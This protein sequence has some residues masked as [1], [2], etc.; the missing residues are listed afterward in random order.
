MKTPIYKFSKDKIKYIPL[1]DLHVGSQSFDEEALLATVEYIRKTPNVYWSI[2]GDCLEN[3]IPGKISP[4][5]QALLPHEQLVRLIE[6]LKPIKH[7]GLFAIDGNHAART[8]RAAYLDIMY[9]ICDSLEIDYIGV[10]GYV[11]FK[12]N[13]IDYKFAVQHGMSGAKNTETELYKM[14]RV[15]IDA[16]V[17]MLGHNHDLY[18]NKKNFLGVNNKGVESIKS[19]IFAR[20]GSYL[21][22]ADYARGALYELRSCG[23]LVFNMS[24]NEKKIK[25]DKIEYLC[26]ELL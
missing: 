2:D 9:V 16:D 18:S 15:Y 3:I 14:H 22:Y 24:G 1:H 11:T 10:G 26:G 6:I 8:K 20:S 17:C 21:S 7:R 13:K 12:L 25:M 5:G 4:T 19:V 23:S